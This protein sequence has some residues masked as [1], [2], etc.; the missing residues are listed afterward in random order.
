MPADVTGMPG[1]ER[2]QGMSPRETDLASRQLRSWSERIK[3]QS[4]FSARTTERSYVDMIKRRLVEV[5]TRSEIPLVA[6]R[7]LRAALVQ[8]G[9]TPER[10]F[11]DNNGRVP[12][13]RPGSIT[14][15][16]SS[17]RIQLI[18]D[19]NLKQARSLGQIAASDDPVF[20]M[21]HPAWRLERTGA[22]KKPRG[23]W[24]RRWADAG[25][26]CGW[27]GAAKTEMAALKTSPIWE[28]LGRGAGNH[29][30]AV[31]SPYPPFAFGSGMA[32]TNVRRSEWKALC[33]KEGIPDGL[34][35][36]R[37]RARQLKRGQEATGGP[38][39]YGASAAGPVGGVLAHL[40]T[41]AR[42][43]WA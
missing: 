28:E 42:T 4:V 18:V 16:S 5:A 24:K 37:E 15:L 19:T 2:L 12:P 22:R 38:G 26:A 31:G 36:I 14:D 6:E 8:L 29:R 35:E 39:A 10:G 7:N 43:P 9:Y 33:A 3:A 27:R 41:G 13:A 11:P 1:A 32:W 20:L 40:G 17:R 34:D 30:D 25:A 23:D 21:A